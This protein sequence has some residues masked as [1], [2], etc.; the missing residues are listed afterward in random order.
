MRRSSWGCVGFR[1]GDVDITNLTGFGFGTSYPHL[2]TELVCTVVGMWWIIGIAG[3]IA[4]GGLGAS[5]LGRCTR[6]ADIEAAA[7]QQ[8]DRRESEISIR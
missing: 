6:R 1:L 5:L 7:E 3:W 4:V 2:D 8:F